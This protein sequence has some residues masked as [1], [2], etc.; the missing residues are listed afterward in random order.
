MN[1]KKH[2][3]M[4]KFLAYSIAAIAIFGIISGSAVYAD[5]PKWA[6][7]EKPLAGK[8]YGFENMLQ[9]KADILGMS[10]DE[11]R[12]Q[13]EDGKTFFQ[14]AE[15]KGVTQEQMRETMKE[16]MEIR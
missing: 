9:N 8:G 13:L 15:E 16:K 4:N 14:I 10:V 3:T 2:K 1:S 11:L 5:G 12:Q 6:V 7:T